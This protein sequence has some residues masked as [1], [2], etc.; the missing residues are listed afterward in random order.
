[1][2]PKKIRNIRNFKQDTGLVEYDV[3]K[4]EGLGEQEIRSG[5][6]GLCSR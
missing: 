3:M 5:K 4:I 1:M 2:Q 6:F